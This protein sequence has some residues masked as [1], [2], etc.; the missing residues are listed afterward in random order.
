MRIVSRG[1]GCLLLNRRMCLE[2]DLK[3]GFSSRKQYTP[4]MALNEPKFNLVYASKEFEEGK[5]KYSPSYFVCWVPA[6]AVAT[7]SYFTSW[8][9]AT[10]ILCGSLFFGGFVYKNHL[11][12]KLSYQ[13]YSV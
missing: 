12:N 13:V 7:F 6:I 2:T 5:L 8:M 9:L 1:K 3:Y 11:Q 4:K 10:K